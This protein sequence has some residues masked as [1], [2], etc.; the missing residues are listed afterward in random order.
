V[1]RDGGD[2]ILS[3]SLLVVRRKAGQASH[4]GAVGGVPPPPIKLEVK[5]G[6]RS[7][8][9]TNAFVYAFSPDD[10]DFGNDAPASSN[11]SVTLE[12]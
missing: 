2:A 9:G 5:A 6:E 7:G 8:E 4:E 12:L 11:P 1:R 3:L 10:A